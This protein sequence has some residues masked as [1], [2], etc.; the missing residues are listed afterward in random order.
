LI[1]NSVLGD[2]DF[3]GDA[4][5]ERKSCR[6]ASPSRREKIKMTNKKMKV[7]ELRD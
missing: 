1:N 2:V 6:I 7:T 5:R 3:V 4:K